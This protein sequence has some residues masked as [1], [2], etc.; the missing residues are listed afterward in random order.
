VSAFELGAVIT[1]P[2]G[3]SED[4]E[5]TEVE[6]GFYA[7]NFVPKEVGVHTISVKFRDIHIPGSPFQYTIG[8]LR[9]YGAHKVHAGGPGLERGEVKTPCEFNV[10]TREAG[11]GSLAISVEGPSK[12]EIDFKDREDGSCYVGYTVAEPG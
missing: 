9:D 2:G 11:S 4:A 10:W 8:P 5:I 7:V 12:G 6:E 1:S 3:V